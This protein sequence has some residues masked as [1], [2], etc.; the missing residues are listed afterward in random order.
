MSEYQSIQ[1]K[2]YR[3]QLAIDNALA[4]ADILA[5]LTLFGYDQ[6]K[7]QA[8]Q[9]LHAQ[10]QSLAIQQEANYGQQYSTTES[11]EN[12]KT[13]ASEQYIKDLSIARVEFKT[14]RGVR[15]KL[16]LDG[17]R[18]RAFSKLLFQARTFY[19]NMANDSNIL[20]RMTPYGF[21]TNLLTQRLNNVNLLEAMDQSQEASK[22]DAQDS[23]QKR[24]EMLREL[25]EFIEKYRTVAFVALANN[26]QW[27]EHLGFGPA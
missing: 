1:E 12:A 17:E 4:D 24:D 21:T 18:E 20:T 22:G 8:A 25:A 6:A 11:L 23:T 26:P 14:E 13:A 3:A 15:A 10:A 5:A 27:L 16:L 7:L 2:L 9:T 19:A